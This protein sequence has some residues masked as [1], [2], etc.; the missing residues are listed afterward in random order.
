MTKDELQQI[1]EACLD[2]LISKTMSESEAM[3]IIGFVGNL[4]QQ[5]QDKDQSDRFVKILKEKLE[6]MQ[7]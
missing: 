2:D 4:R 3:L 6:E 1:I 5:V 7:N